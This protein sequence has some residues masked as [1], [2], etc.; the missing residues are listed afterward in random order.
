[1]AFLTLDHFPPA[2]TT[3]LHP[4][5]FIQPKPLATDAPTAPAPRAQ[6]QSVQTNRRRTEVAP[7]PVVG[8]RKQ[9][10]KRKRKKAD[11]NSLNAS[12][13]R[14]VPIMDDDDPDAMDTEDV[15]EPK[16]R[17]VQAGDG[18]KDPMIVCFYNL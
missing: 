3:F 5:H 15:D 6:Q 17:K 1:M 9:P 18:M 4:D 12:Y 13:I 16:A 10:A 2:K 11:S 14:L 8:T 7:A